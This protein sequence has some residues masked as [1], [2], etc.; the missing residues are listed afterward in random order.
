[1]EEVTRYID[2]KDYVEL[3]LAGNKADL[4]DERVIYGVDRET[5]KV[6]TTIP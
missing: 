4:E 1:M 6:N 5:A 2:S 3:V